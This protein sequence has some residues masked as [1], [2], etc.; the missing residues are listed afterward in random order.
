MFR[1]RERPM[2]VAIIFSARCNL[3]AAGAVKLMQ[4]CFE[5]ENYRKFSS[6]HILMWAK[7]VSSC[8]ERKKQSSVEQLSSEPVSCEN[9]PSVRK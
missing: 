3:L 9:D 2:R 4:T 1:D 5:S 8:S 7:L 6:D